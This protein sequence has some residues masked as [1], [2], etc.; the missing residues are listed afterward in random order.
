MLGRDDSRQGAGVGTWI[1]VSLFEVEGLEMTAGF[2][3]L[4]DTVEVLFLGPD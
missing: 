3:R 2:R 1:G 4:I